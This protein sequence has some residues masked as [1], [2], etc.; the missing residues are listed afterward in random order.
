[1]SPFFRPR[2]TNDRNLIPV[3]SGK[4]NALACDVCKNAKLLTGL[5]EG[6]G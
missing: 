5:K 6:L 1:M 4:R 3:R 2:D